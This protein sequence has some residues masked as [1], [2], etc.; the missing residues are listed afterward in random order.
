M[1]VQALYI[2]LALISFILF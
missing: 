2:Y 1:K